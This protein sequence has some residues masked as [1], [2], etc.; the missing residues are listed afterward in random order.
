MLQVPQYDFTTFNYAEGLQ[1]DSASGPLTDWDWLGPS[2]PVQHLALAVMGLGQ[3]LPISPPAP[4]ASWTLD[5]WGPAL[6]CN[7]VTAEK[8]DKIWLNIWNSY[9]ATTT[10]AYAFLSWVPWSYV[11]SWAYYLNLTASGID[12]DLPFFLNLTVQGT[13]IGP[14]TSSVS[15]EGPASLFVAVLPQSLNLTVYTNTGTGA[16]Y[17]GIV[18]ENCPYQTVQSLDEPLPGCAPG[19]TTFT[20]SLVYEDSTLLRCDLVNTSYRVEFN[21]SSGA[22]D[23]RIRPNMTGHSP[24]VDGS[25]YFVGPQPPGL[26][27]ETFPANCSTFLANPIPDASGSPCVFDIDALR[28]VSY[29]GIMAAFNQL[30]LGAIQNQA[31]SLAPNTSIMRT[32]L[33]ETAELAPIRN[34]EPSWLGEPSFQTMISGMPGW[35]YPGLSN[36]TPPDSHGSLKSTLEQLFQNLTIS[37]L[38]EPYLQ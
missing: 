19:N 2:Q 26:D 1:Y 24:I 5:F 9:N 23:V 35:A 6:Q 3:I 16:D 12:R 25:A 33:G 7:H 21:Y 37:L 20:P 13:P 32:V 8:R 30:L 36:P 15:T 28:L 17:D 10:G 11:D 38:A 4:N 29:Q 18:W 22:Q 34:W 31:G 27:S 14:A